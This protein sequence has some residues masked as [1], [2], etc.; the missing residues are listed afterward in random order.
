MDDDQPPRMPDGVDRYAS[1]SNQAWTSL[2][3]L[4]GGMVVWGLIG[5]L[6]DVWL[7]LGGI[8]TGIGILLGAAGGIVLI[9]RT[10]TVQEGREED[11]GRH[12]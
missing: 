3:Y 6:V 8:A 12:R 7:G 9:V 10:V 5:W 1:G 4:I 2:G 11:N